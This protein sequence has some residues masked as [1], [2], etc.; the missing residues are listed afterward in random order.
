MLGRL[1]AAE[2]LTPSRA[3]GHGAAVHATKWRYPVRAGVP[4]ALQWPTGVGLC[5]SGNR[6]FQASAPAW[7]RAQADSGYVQN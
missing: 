3:V 7:L 4:D 6:H 2:D 5:V 1:C